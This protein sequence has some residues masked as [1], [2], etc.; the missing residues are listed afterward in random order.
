[1]RIGLEGVGVDHTLVKDKTVPFDTWH[2]VN[3]NISQWGYPLFA[4]H[5]PMTS[6]H[7]GPKTY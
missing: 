3:L 7:E 4:G 2:Y 1:M 6:A 5:V